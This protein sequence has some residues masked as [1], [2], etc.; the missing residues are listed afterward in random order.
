MID[1]RK[2]TDAELALFKEIQTEMFRPVQNAISH[3]KLTETEAV[4]MVANTLGTMIAV[5]S[6]SIMTES[7]AM[8]MSKSNLDLGRE[9][10]RSAMKKELGG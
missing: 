8:E 1:L 4:A 6:P 3:G 2:A 5:I 7:D 9:M 10:A